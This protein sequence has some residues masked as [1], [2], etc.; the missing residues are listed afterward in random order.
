MWGVGASED[1]PCVICY[2]LLYGLYRISLH[3]KT[4][5][6]A[7]FKEAEEQF[8][9]TYDIRKNPKTHTHA[10]LTA[11]PSQPKTH[12]LRS[13]TS[14]RAYSEK[15]R[16]QNQ[17]IQLDALRDDIQAHCIHLVAALHRLG[18]LRVDLR[19]THACVG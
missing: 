7:H 13:E 8:I 12:L 18:E 2:L 3:L 6:N 1:A 16:E 19:V 11:T 4:T 14:L 15:E 17:L 5:G 10:Q 9:D